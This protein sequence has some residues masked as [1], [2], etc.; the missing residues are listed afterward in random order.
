[1]K[2]AVILTVYKRYNYVNEAINSIFHQTVLP[3]QI[4]MITDNTKIIENTQNIRNLTIIEA[5]YPDYG[6]KI[7]QAINSL[8]DDIDIIFF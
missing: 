5:N 8:D 1:M 4:V 3:D 7:V 2:T 6:K